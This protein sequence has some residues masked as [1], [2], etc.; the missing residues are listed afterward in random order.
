MPA[1]SSKEYINA[2]LALGQDLKRTSLRTL[3][4]VNCIDSSD[5]SMDTA[6]LKG[7]HAYV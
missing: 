3:K 6:S 4:P 7:D 1:I 2:G 5:A